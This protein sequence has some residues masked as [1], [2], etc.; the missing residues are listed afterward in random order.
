MSGRSRE[1]AP[2]PW[3]ALMERR[4]RGVEAR[5]RFR[6]RQ[7]H[8][9]HERPLLL[10]ARLRPRATYFVRSGAHVG[11]ALGAPLTFFVC[12]VD[13]RVVH[14]RVARAKV[15]GAGGGCSGERGESLRAVGSRTACRTLW[16]LVNIEE[17]RALSVATP[18]VQS[19][20]CHVFECDGHWL[21]G[22]RRRGSGS[23][24]LTFAPPLQGG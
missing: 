14:E 20:L 16:R 5:A 18:T 17:A 9:A 24:P 13:S 10:E 21:I 19:L 8:G 15:E 11:C 4:V 1:G 2:A 6:E 23:K 3:P 7:R 12:D 22:V